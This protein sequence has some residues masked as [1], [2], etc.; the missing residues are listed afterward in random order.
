MSNTAIPLID[1]GPLFRPAAPARDAVD[2]AIMAAA[3]GCGFMTVTGC[4]GDIP[5]GAGPRR[6]LLR[7]FDATPDLLQTLARNTSDPSRPFVY[8]GWFP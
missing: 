4:P 2:R 8:H 3:T 1:I 7:L 5:I 6:E